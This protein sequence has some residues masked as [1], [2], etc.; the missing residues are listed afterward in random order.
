MMICLRNKFTFLVT[1]FLNIWAMNSKKRAPNS[2][3]TM[4]RF[5][6]S[7]FSLLISRSGFRSLLN[8]NMENHSSLHFVEWEMSEWLHLNFIA[9]TYMYEIS[10]NI[11]RYVIHYSQLIIDDWMR[12][13]CHP[14]VFASIWKL[15]ITRNNNNTNNIYSNMTL[16]KVNNFHPN[17]NNSKNKLNIMISVGRKC[18]VPC[19]PNQTSNS[20]FFSGRF[21]IQIRCFQN[22][23]NRLSKE[24]WKWNE[25]N[26]LNFMHFDSPSCTNI[27]THISVQ[28]FTRHRF[29]QS[30]PKTLSSFMK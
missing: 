6:L 24:S 12:V 4:Y 8:F 16:T 2:P 15:T 29:G 5:S 22:P 23:K 13:G 7:F 1:F 19:S 20:V 11:F 17:N 3:D 21:F 10:H 28:K 26:L 9:L 18:I 25:N 14:P 30:Q 27:H